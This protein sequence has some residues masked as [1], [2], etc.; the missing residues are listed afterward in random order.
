M[1]QT[2]QETKEGAK[3]LETRLETLY[4]DG[5]RLVWNDVTKPDNIR[6]GT[7]DY[8][9]TKI[10][11]EVIQVVWTKP[12]TEN[13]STYVW[14]LNFETGK[15]YGVIINDRTQKLKFVQGDFHTL[16]GVTPSPGNKGC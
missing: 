11:P 15:T 3:S 13:K 4:C 8:T 16:S 1:S 14:T 7:A 2:W 10:A 12:E 5:K 9:L 6:S